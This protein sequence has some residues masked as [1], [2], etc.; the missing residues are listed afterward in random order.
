MAGCQAGLGRVS[1]S[2]P[3]KYFSFCDIMSHVH[4]QK[5]IEELEAQLQE[6]EDIVKELREEL[7]AVEAQ[8]SKFTKIKEVKHPNPRYV[9]IPLDKK[10]PFIV[11]TNENKNTD[12]KDEVLEKEIVLEQ[13]KEMDIAANNSCERAPLDKK[14]SF[15]VKTNDD[16]NPKSISK[17]DEVLDKEIVLVQ[18]K[19]IDIAADNSCL[20]SPSSVKHTN[21]TT[22]QENSKESKAIV[23]D[24]EITCN[25][26]S[27]SQ[28]ELISMSQVTNKVELPIRSSRQSF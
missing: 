25:S 7:R 19:E 20:T 10:L 23:K 21:N 5:K 12:K 15:S 14:L 8:L 17:E 2:S 26:Q 27:T 16:N 13:V 22:I 28:E 24:L 1:L 4:P 6:A 18:V 3:C 9:T 11:K